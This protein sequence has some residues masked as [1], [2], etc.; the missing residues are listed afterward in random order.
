MRLAME[1]HDGV[2]LA[3]PQVGVSRRIALVSFEGAFYAL[4]NPVL[5]EQEGEQEGEEGC[6]SFPGIY[7]N[8]KRP[9]K[10]RVAARDVAGDECVY[11]AEGFL[12]RAFLHE[13]DHL[14]GKLFIEYLSNLKR[15][16]IRKKMYKRA[17]GD[18]D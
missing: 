1:M 5:L 13:I 8:V 16:M 3:A 7:A 18:D 12:A 14:D 9:A 17:M 11:E 2:G 4:I 15:G 10:I 6:L